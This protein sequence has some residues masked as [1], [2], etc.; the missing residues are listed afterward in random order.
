MNRATSIAF[1]FCLSLLVIACQNQLQLWKTQTAGD[2][3]VKKVPDRKRDYQGNPEAGF[4]YL[5]YGSYIGTGIPYEL[6]KKKV[7]KEKDTILRRTGA[8]AYV[9]PGA[10]I[11]S[12]ENGI[13]VLNGNCFTCHS[14][15]VNGK[16]YIGIGNSLETY[17]KNFSLQAKLL[18]KTINRKLKD[19]SL[20][21]QAYGAFGK[22]YQAM[23][24]DIELNNPG[25]NPAFRL[26]EAC[27]Q[28]RD[29][30]SLEYQEEKRFDIIP[31]SLGADVPPLWHVKKKNMLYYNGSGR[32]DFTKLLMQASVLG[33][34]DSTAA[35]KAHANFEDVLAWLESLE[36]P[37]YPKAIDQQLASKGRK[38]FEN[39]CSKCHGT[40]G[41]TETYPNKIVSINLVKT[42]PGYALYTH[43]SPFNDWYN[44]SWFAQSPPY[45]S[46]ESELGYVAPPLDGIWATAPYLHNG[47]VPTLDALLNSQT[48]PAY[49]KRSKDSKDYDWEK[50]GWKVIERSGPG[51]KSTYDTSL[52]GY[53]NQGHYFGD[54][55]TDAER[56]AVIEYLKTL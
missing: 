9:G 15:E 16:T 55:L 37:E 39:K 34:K 53:G 56:K 48:R 12:A 1:I 51:G 29:P 8:N 46:I 11:F 27:V 35:R 13:Q 47:S 45:S 38:V 43:Q 54:K 7:E 5:V 26:T 44:E 23:A 36:A 10:N 28:H 22:F 14:A 49:W 40:Y 2:W 24:P 17:E 6:I 25:V 52:P 30:L 42:D 41:E 33:I 31:Y 18:E 20:T 50:V 4:N 19:D 21:L 3:K 32:G